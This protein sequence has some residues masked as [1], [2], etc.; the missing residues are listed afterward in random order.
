MHLTL[1]TISQEVFALAMFVSSVSA[2]S[3]N[4]QELQSADAAFRA[5]YAAAQNGN[6]A[7]ARR[8]FLNVVVLAPGIG[9]GHSAL[10]AVLV[11][12]GEFPAAIAELKHALSLNNDDPAAQAN[13]A[14]AYEQTGD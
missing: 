1:K 13:L 9:A 4:K 7:E 12:L 14:I 8:Q 3:Q 2:L 10:G 11:Q 5:G 6:L